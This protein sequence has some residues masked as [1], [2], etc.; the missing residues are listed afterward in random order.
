MNFR[1]ILHLLKTDW[2][3]FKWPIICMWIC[4]IVTVAPWLLHD[5]V[6]F[7]LPLSNGFS[8]GDVESLSLLRP[9][10]HLADGRHFAMLAFALPVLLSTAIG[11]HDQL[12][13]SVSP[14]RPWQRIV[15]KAVAL[16]LFIVLPQLL[17]G[18][19]I[20]MLNGF[21]PAFI[22]MSAMS[23]GLQLML[24]HGMSAIFGRCCGSLWLWSAAVTCLAGVSYLIDSILW[25]IY[26]PRNWISILL[27]PWTIQSGPLECVQA[28]L[29]LV[30]VAA[31]PWMVRSRR[32]SVTG[33]V[34]AVAGLTASSY[35]SVWPVRWHGSWNHPLRME[36]VQPALS[37]E[38]GRWENAKSWET[39]SDSD[40]QHFKIAVDAK[41]LECRTFVKWEAFPSTLPDKKQYFL[42][43]R[44]Y[45]M[46]TNTSEVRVAL[47]EALPVPFDDSY[48]DL[49]TP[50]VDIGPDVK[51]RPPTSVP[52]VGR[53]FRWRMIADLP[54]GESAVLATS[55]D[56]TVAAR[57]NNDK[58]REPGGE[59]MVKCPVQRTSFTY[60]I[61][62]PKAGRCFRPLTTDTRI[63]APPGGTVWFNIDLGFGTPKY[64]Q[65]EVWEN[66][67]VFVLQPEFLGTISRRLDLP[68]VI[69]TTVTGADDWVL[70][71][72]RNGWR[73][74]IYYSDLRPNR[75][76]PT[77]CSEREFS[78]YLRMVDA[79]HPSESAVRD[80]AEYAPRFPRL[81][82]LYGRNDFVAS[83]IESGVPEFSK[84]EVLGAI[85]SPKQAT[86]L[87]I[88]LA[89]R[90]WQD[91]ARG[92]LLS[93]LG[94]P[95]I[96]QNRGGV[97]PVVS[98]IARSEDPSTYPTLLSAYEATVN[99]RCYDIIRPLAGIALEL[100]RTVERVSL[101]LAKYHNL[102]GEPF[103]FSDGTREF[104]APVSHGNPVAFA[105]FLQVTQEPGEFPRTPDVAK[106]LAIIRPASVFYKP[107]TWREFFKGK[108]IADFAY[109]PLARCWRP[110]TKNH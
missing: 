8:F 52:L 88:T 34:A 32:E 9:S 37:A 104:G 69:D 49:G 57:L 16:F 77:T 38:G 63:G 13:Q 54:L 15:A 89:D 46:D 24:L 90:D 39:G 103:D 44:Q 55:G 30:L 101:R 5:P 75:P 6:S 82:G 29:A 42:N 22:I 91:G 86:S 7:D 36:S 94:T 110:I 43:D 74:D 48:T 76:D 26:V 65:T 99:S 31:L 4:L 96:S 27:G 62:L 73:H 97:E 85:T 72:N 17:L 47:R 23:I 71:H 70:T 109:D 12:W 50:L 92:P 102:N 1:I 79:L 11:M 93:S 56:I 3:R 40:R 35:L 100:D 105:K 20:S 25:D 98:A 68:P 81:L 45:F 78:R 60:L 28:G 18:I 10:F 83:V 108:T 106:L 66:A 53:V 58:V 87:A 14:I 33:I 51:T 59:L 84:A 80:L 61:Y 2:L 107:E 67:R 41:G 64:P 19:A 21:S 95:F